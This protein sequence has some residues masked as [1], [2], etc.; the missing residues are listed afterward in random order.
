MKGTKYEITD[1]C[2]SV[3]IFLERNLANFRLDSNKM[4]KFFYSTLKIFIL[5]EQ[6]PSIK[7]SEL[8]EQSLVFFSTCKVLFSSLFSSVYEIVQYW[9]R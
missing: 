3:L 1:H 8:V 6:S 2:C 5:K 7:K 4:L 9:R